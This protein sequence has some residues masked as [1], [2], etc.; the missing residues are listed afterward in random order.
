[1]KVVVLAGGVG[2]ARLAFGLQ[3]ALPPHDL[4]VIVNTG[5]DFDHLGLRIC[6]DLDTVTYTLAG[7][8]N[9]ETGWGLAGDTFEALAALERVGGPAWFRL[10]DRDLA[11]HLQRTSLLSQGLRLTEVT[12]RL[13]AALG[14]PARVLPMTDDVVATK[15]L[16]TE[17]ELDFQDYFVRRRCEP[18]VKGVRFAGIETTLPSPDADAALRDADGIV[19]APSNPF[20]SVEPILAL[21]GLRDAVASKTVVAVSPI[22]GGQAIKGPAAKMLRELGQDVSAAGVARRY[23]GLV[24]GFVMD[25]QDASLEGEVS[26]LGFETVLA[27]TIMRSDAERESLARV[28]LELLARVLPS[29]GR[30][31]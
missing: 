10:G 2:G 29:R 28:C 21:P 15:V 11:T 16:T 9:R 8:A 18:E 24:G 22:V 4:T 31:R 12:A 5:D 3:R 20:V 1:M 7:L 30:S 25:R 27:Q 13:C 14:V 19:I 26:A 6:P 17:G 23:A